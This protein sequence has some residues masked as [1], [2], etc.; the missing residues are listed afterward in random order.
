MKNRINRMKER[1][2]R[3]SAK[4]KIN[5]IKRLKEEDQN[6]KNKLL[7]HLLDSQTKIFK[8]LTDLEY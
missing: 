3:L 5:E 4:E 8:L 2:L 7:N 6:N 1:E